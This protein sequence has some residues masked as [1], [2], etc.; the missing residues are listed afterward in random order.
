MQCRRPTWEQPSE[1]EAV[2]TEPWEHRVRDGPVWSDDVDDENTEEDQEISPS[3]E[4]IQHMV[5][6]LLI[7]KISAKDFCIAMHW[8]SE[9][10]LT[11]A[12]KW[13]R[14]PNLSS[15]KYADHVNHILGHTL[16]GNL[17]TMQVP[18][19]VKGNT[20][21][22]KID[23]HV[24]PPHETLDAAVSEHET[25]RARLQE[26]VREGSLPECYFQNPVVLAKQDHELVGPY[27]LFFDGVPYSLVDSVLGVWLSCLITGQRFLLAIV[28]K[29]RMCRCG[30]RQWCT[31]WAL[32]D[33]LR[34]CISALAAGIYPSTRHDGSGWGPQDGERANLAGQKMQMKYVLLHI[35]SDWMEYVTSFGFPLWSDALRPC[36]D[37]NA[38]METRNDATGCTL[39]NLVWQE[40][41][42][43][44][45]F[46]ACER[47]E[48]IVTV[49]EADHE[50][51]CDLL[52]PDKRANGSH[53]LALRSDYDPLRLSKG[54]RL[55]P[56]ETLNDVGDFFTQAR[57]PLHRITFW[58]PPR[59]FLTKHRNPIF[60]RDLGLTPNKILTK[61][62]LHV[63]YLGIM[64]SLCRNILWE[65]LLSDVLANL[66]TQEEKSLLAW[67]G[68]TQT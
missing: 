12:K 34:Y 63:V 14:K 8:A 3:E 23:L 36:M 24:L 46:D 64:L 35:K 13:A 38:T 11:S 17:Y 67:L 9:A 10:G 30:C 27:A 55:E 49:D 28:R 45:Y 5:E 60:Q 7:R 68:L 20:G 51:L 65:I 29:R 54:D 40:N 37:C 62:L 31:H 42:D 59:D 32:F 53:G 56:C 57:F 61:D 25:Y 66:G 19:Y 15:G 16:N 52:V 58:R 18:G 39:G 43:D 48:C 1:D 2:A 22:S 41:D 44:A 4:F 33:W 6:L 47:C 26:R 50:N 21:R